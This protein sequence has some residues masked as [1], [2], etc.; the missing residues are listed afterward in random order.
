MR[1][2]FITNLFPY[3]ENEMS[4]IF[5]TNRLKALTTFGTAFEAYGII[6]KD[7][8]GTISLKGS[9]LVSILELTLI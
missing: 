6:S 7:T 9:V 3:P 1:V 5:I 8:F 2:L 4:G